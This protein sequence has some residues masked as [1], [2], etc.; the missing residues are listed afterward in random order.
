VNASPLIYLTRAGLLDVLNEPGIPVMVPDE[1]LAELG[2][3]SPN[4]P[5]ALA[6]V[7]STWLQVVPT[8]PIPVSVQA[9]N[10]DA[11][12]SAVLAVALGQ[13]DSQAILD[14]LAARRCARALNVPLQGT[15]GLILVAKELGM[16][17]AVRPV[18][19][20]L[21]QTGMYVS[22]WLARQVLDQAGE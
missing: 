2:R 20:A 9:W 13:P 16:I 17:S 19:D 5:A 21:R 6:V 15:L 7:Q 4:D 22:N 10:L 18:L 12:E 14:D 1:V 11:G 8:P 3:L